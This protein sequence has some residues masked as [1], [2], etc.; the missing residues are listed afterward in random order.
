MCK[1][2][3]DRAVLLCPGPALPANQNR[4]TGQ[5]HNF[6]PRLG[7]GLWRRTSTARLARE[8]TPLHQPDRG[9]I[10]S[11]RRAPVTPPPADRADGPDPSACG[12]RRATGPPMHLKRTLRAPD[13]L[14]L[15]PGPDGA[16][17]A[18]A[19]ALVNRYLAEYSTARQFYPAAVSRVPPSSVPTGDLLPPPPRVPGVDRIPPNV[20]VRQH[21]APKQGRSGRASAS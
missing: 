19:V 13:R 11:P 9:H 6:S 7:G 18:I 8:A 21:S 15:S 5:G 3:Y 2:S 12:S 14:L 10:H 16:G 4:R 17:F 20:E 1:L